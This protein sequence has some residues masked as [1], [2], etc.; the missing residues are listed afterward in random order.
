MLKQKIK[1]QQTAVHLLFIGTLIM[2]Q[3]RS[4]F[5][6]LCTFRFEKLV[7]FVLA[8]IVL[9]GRVE[10]E[11]VCGAQSLVDTV[12]TGIIVA[13]RPTESTASAVQ[14]RSLTC[15]TTG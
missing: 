8:I 14:A 5:Y 10:G 2:L 13:N 12:R 4:N 9:S 3:P 6:F 1:S 7:H 15:S 11:R